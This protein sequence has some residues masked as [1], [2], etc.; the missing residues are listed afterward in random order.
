MTALARAAILVAVAS[1]T[2]PD[3]ATVG[4]AVR[5]APSIAW[6]V[7]RHVFPPGWDS[8]TSARVERDLE[9][10]AELGARYVRT[11]L[12]WFA[13]ERSPGQ[14]DAAALAYYRWYVDAAAARGLGVVTILSGMPNWAHA[15]DRDDL[16]DAFGRYAERVAAVVGDR[17]TM[18]QLWNEPNHVIDVPDHD[19]DIRLFVVGRAGIERGRQ[20]IGAT[21]PFVTAIN[22]LVDGHDAPFGPS[23]QND[24][25][26]YL[27]HGARDAI[28][29]IAI[30][31]YP[32]TWSFG[33][34]GGRVLDRL[35]ALGEEQDKA[36]AIFEVG[37]STPPCT[38]PA[39]TEAAQARWIREQLPRMR[40]KLTDPAVTRGVPFS[41]VNWFKLDD[42]NT[43]ACLD[44][45]DHFGVVRTDRSKK[46]AFAALAAE[47]AAF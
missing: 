44:P 15:L 1:C 19:T 28:D 41:L 14:Y 38:M 4:A 11:D 25:R 17:V 37:Y 29:V 9:L 32:S 13:I 23:W 12:W 21:Q 42:R 46:P 36:V 40:A 45:E 33:D 35:F 5:S 22:V 47:I 10:V 3:D 18:Y 39:H 20:A 8:D 24:V 30:D 16:A 6:S 2:V 34:W 27:E 7:S 43:S 26:Y 31:H